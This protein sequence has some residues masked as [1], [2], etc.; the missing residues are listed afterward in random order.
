[1][2]LLII[3]PN[4]EQQEYNKQLFWFYFSHVNKN[5]PFAC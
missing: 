3:L 1:M 5:L 2:F 4:T